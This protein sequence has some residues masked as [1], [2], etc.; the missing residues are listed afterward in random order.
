MAVSKPTGDG[1]HKDSSGRGAR[2]VG[3][4]RVMGNEITPGVS[5]SIGPP[6]PPDR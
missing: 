6:S 1:A 4:I 3:V 5:T 2:A